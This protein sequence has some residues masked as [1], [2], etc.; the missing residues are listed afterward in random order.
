MRVLII[1]EHA[2]AAKVLRRELGPGAGCEVLGYVD[3]REPCGATIA[4]AD[5]DVVLVDDMGNRADTL[6]RVRETRAAV[7]ATKL[8]LTTTRMEPSWLSDVAGAGVDAAIARRVQPGSLG[9][10][11]R[12]VARGNLFHAFDR[13]PEK[14]RRHKAAGLTA[15]ELEILRLVAAGAANAGIA[16]ELW[17]TEQTVKFHLSNV[18]RKLGVSN[19][20]QASHFAH[21]NGLIEPAPKAGHP[22]LAVAA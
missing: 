19:R 21:V 11:L 12:E 15:R 8:V 17:V 7:P 6:A 3:G 9:L 13:V 22:A 1:A 16:R 2:L 4:Q 10:L 14:P 20:T 18:Y 5:P